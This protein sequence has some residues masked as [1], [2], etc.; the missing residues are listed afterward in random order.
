[1]KVMKLVVMVIDMDNLGEDAIKERIELC[2]DIYPEVQSIEAREITGWCDD[3]PLNYRPAS[4]Q[5]FERL[6]SESK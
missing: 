4:K 1:M 3:H 6:F 5:E 2:R